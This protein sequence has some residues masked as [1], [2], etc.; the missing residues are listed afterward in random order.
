MSHK[1]S[2]LRGQIVAGGL[3]AAVPISLLPPK[4]IGLGGHG[5]SERMPGS[6]TTAPMGQE[7]APACH[8]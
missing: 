1:R 5:G 7:S 2:G 3:D 8:G 4:R 6:M